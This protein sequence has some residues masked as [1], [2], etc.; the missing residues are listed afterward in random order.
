M[1]DPLD[2]L[3]R[4]GDNVTEDA[5]DRYAVLDLAKTTPEIRLA[6]RTIAKERARHAALGMLDVAIEELDGM[7]YGKAARH[8][9]AIKEGE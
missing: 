6:V 3:V 1:T 5:M 9:R 2:T 4:E 8:L 7:G